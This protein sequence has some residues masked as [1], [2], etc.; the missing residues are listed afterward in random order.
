ME[1]KNIDSCCDH[2]FIVKSKVTAFFVFSL[3]EIWI[4]RFLSLPPLPFIDY[5]KIYGTASRFEAIKKSFVQNKKIVQNEPESLSPP[6]PLCAYVCRTYFGKFVFTDEPLLTR[7]IGPADFQSASQFAI[8]F[9]SLF[10][11][12]FLYTLVLIDKVLINSKMMEKG[13]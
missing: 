2:P 3:C 4:S 13:F 11:F 9:F 12:F 8:S 10:F 5:K 1:G 7:I 6:L